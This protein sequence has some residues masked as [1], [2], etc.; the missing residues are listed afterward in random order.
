MHAM[1]GSVEGD[2]SEAATMDI[3]DGNRNSKQSSGAVS[4]NLS[5]HSQG[6][7]HSNRTHILSHPVPLPQ[8]GN[9][10]RGDRIH[11]D[12]SVLQSSSNFQQGGNV[13]KP[14]PDELDIKPFVN[15]RPLPIPTPSRE[16]MLTQKLE[17]ALGTVCPL[18]REIMID[19]APFLSK[20]LIGS[21]GQDLLI[22]GKVCHVLSN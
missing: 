4:P 11:Q 22:E 10:V 8:Q 12:I 1:V 19:F 9:D 3:T 14:R 18:L 15:E 21:H 20:T 16:A 5:Q 7:H 6:S 13:S 17:V 2:V